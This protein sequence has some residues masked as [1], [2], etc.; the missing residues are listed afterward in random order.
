M[1]TP[2]TAL[3]RVEAVLQ[4]SESGL[5]IHQ[6]AREADVTEKEAKAA[7]KELAAR[8]QIELIPTPGRWGQRYAWLAAK[9]LPKV[10]TPEAPAGQPETRVDAEPEPE[11]PADSGQ[12]NAAEQATIAGDTLPEIPMLKGAPEEA[13]LKAF[14]E[15]GLTKPDMTQGAESAKAA[16]RREQV[17]TSNEYAKAFA[18][19]FGRIENPRYLVLVP[20][21][22]PRIVKSRA[23]AEALAL[24]AVRRGAHAA[25][26]CELES[27]GTARRD[28]VFVE[29]GA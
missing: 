16:Y 5:F 9:P 10:A 17:E 8:A 24:A 15:S 20:K 23:R 6:I 28:A 2:T 7:V 3:S 22:K 29:T 14:A 18:R 26:V 4:A 25:E 13:I 11:A 19:L 12:E 21:R 27:I 1:D